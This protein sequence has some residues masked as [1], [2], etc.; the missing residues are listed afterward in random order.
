MYPS[1]LTNSL[2]LLTTSLTLSTSQ[3]VSPPQDLIHTIGHANISIRY[4]AVPT[5]ICEL[6]P[7]VKSYTGYADVAEDQHIFF[8]FFEARDV[9]PSEA[10]LTVWINGGP[11]ST[12]MFGLFQELGPCGIDKDG[13]VVDNEFS[14]SRTSNL[15]FVDQPTQVSSIGGFKYI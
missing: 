5:G 8:W 12:S 4:K 14:W 15:L 6:D 11:G 10:P 9:D 13:E 1:S 2:L 3:F 7:T